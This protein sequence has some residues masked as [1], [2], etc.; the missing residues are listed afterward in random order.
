MMSKYWRKIFLLFITLFNINIINAATYY[1]SSIA[2]NPNALG[3]WWTNTNN[4]GTNPANFTTAGDIFIIQT[5]HTYTTTAAWNVTGTIQVEGSLTIGT[6]N[7]IGSLTIVT[8]GLVTGN[9]PTTISAAGTFTIQDG[10]KYILNHTLPNT[11]TTFNGAESFSANSTFEYQNLINPGTFVSG[12]TYGNFIYNTSLSNIFPTIINING[13]FEMKQGTLD[14]SSARTIGGNFI[15]S[16][17]TVLLKSST[18]NGNYNQTGGTATLESSTIKGNMLIDGAS[19]VTRITQSTSTNVDAIIE[20]DLEVKNG[21]FQMNDGPQNTPSFATDLF[22]YGNFTVN[23]G[24]F[25]TPNSATSAVAGRIFVSKDVRFLSGVIGGFLSTSTSTAGIYFEGPNEQTFTNAF[26]FTTGDFKN[27][28]YFKTPPPA[29]FFIN[30]QYIGTSGQQT[31]VNGSFGAP[32]AGYNRW[33]PA[34]TTNIIRTFTIN[35]P[36]GVLLRDSRNIRD[37]LYRTVGSIIPETGSDVISYSTGATLE[38]NGTTA[39]TS[40]SSE[41]PSTNGPTNLNINNPG[42]VTLHANR[43]LNGLLIFSADNGLLNTSTCNATTTGTAVLTLNDNADVIGESS[44]RYVNGIMTKV[45][46]EAFVFPIGQKTLTYSKYAPVQIS[47]SGNTLASYSACYIGTNPNPTYNTISKDAS[48]VSPT[49]YKVSTCEYWNINKGAGSPDVFV[50][51]SWAFGRSCAFSNALDLVVA[52][53][54]IDLTPDA[55]ANRF[56]NGSNTPGPSSPAQTTGW[57]TSASTISKWGTFTLAHPN[58]ATA[59]LNNADI[60]TLRASRI[61][62]L[63]Q[64]NWTLTSACI[65]ASVEVERSTDGARFYSILQ[66][67]VNDLETCRLYMQYQLSDNQS[68]A[69]YRLKAVLPN[70][71]IMHSNIVRVQGKNTPIQIFPNP[72]LNQIKLSGVTKNIKEFMIYNQVGQIIYSEKNIQSQPYTIAATQ[73]RSGI[74]Y[75]RLIFD[76]GEIENHKIIKQ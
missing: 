60:I 48:L 22:I 34:T 43:S 71:N 35:N 15:Q 39:I 14:F 63:D 27:A 40:E 64:L 1:S 56:N 3:N 50:T 9:A 37:T 31:S 16:G 13:N 61:N 58:M 42:S 36:D 23:G 19:A 59:T 41:F 29:T 21:T 57:V 49:D 5:G 20:G 55:W 44:L 25:N 51:L 72:I 7:S 52:H 75:L 46:D 45:G 24:T 62:L 26:S 28:F 53:W 68:S 17:G 65:N 2:S 47:A 76:N 12:I 30:E 70:G 8:G 54:D 69:Y 66:F 33:P 10:G 38:Y 18:I 4:T 32:I 6:A 11:A 74:Y 73:W 67:P